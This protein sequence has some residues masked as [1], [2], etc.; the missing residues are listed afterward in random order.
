MNVVENAVKYSPRDGIVTINL[1]WTQDFSELVVE[2]AGP[3]IPTEQLPYIF[4]RF[5]RGSQMEARVKGFGLGLAIA[6]KIA[7]LHNATLEAGNSEGSGAKFS[8]RIKNI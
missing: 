1:N 7:I 5:S 2:D 6:Q 3:G 8:F 4:E